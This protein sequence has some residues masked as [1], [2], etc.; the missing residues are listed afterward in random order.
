MRENMI[1]PKTLLKS[2][3]DKNKCFHPVLIHEVSGYNYLSGET[4][5]C[6]ICDYYFNTYYSKININNFCEK[7]C[8]IDKYDWTDPKSVIKKYINI[9]CEEYISEKEI[10]ISSLISIFSKDIYEDSSVFKN[11]FQKRKQ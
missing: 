6:A 2:E 9:I 8:I 3:I 7:P 1:N 4:Y 11:Y 10:N 5:E